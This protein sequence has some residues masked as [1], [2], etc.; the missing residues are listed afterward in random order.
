M[1][2]SE[3]KSIVEFKQEIPDDN[4]SVEYEIVPYIKKEQN[5][6]IYAL[7]QRISSID[8]EIEKLNSEIDQL[9]NHADGLDYIVAVS[10]G[11]LCGIIDSIFV[12]E[13]NFEHAKAI[14]NEE[15]NRK[16]MAFAKKKGW[17]PHEG[18]GE[19]LDLA[20]KY[21]EKKYPL[22]GDG[23]FEQLAGSGITKNTH[24]IDDFC[25]HPN[26]VGLICCLLVQF[27]GETIYYNNSGTKYSIPILV[28]D[29]GQLQ[30]TT[31]V[32][33]FFCGIINWFITVAKT[34]ANAKGHWMSDIAGSGTSKHGGAGLPGPVMSLLKELSALPCFKDS[35]FSE[36]LRKVYQ[37]GIGTGKKQIDLGIFNS[38][39]E[40]ASSKFDIRT[41]NAVKHELKRQAVP[42]V[43][44]EAL[45][46][47][48]YT[49]RHFIAEY[50]LK[51]DFY[52][53]DWKNILPFKNRTIIRMLTISTGTFTAFDLADATIRSAVKNA[54]Q[55]GSPLFI[56]DIILRVNFVGI[57]RFAIAISTDVSMEVKKST[58]EYKRIELFI[59]QN[60]LLNAKIFYRQQEMWIQ[61]AN[62]ESSAKKLLKIAEQSIQFE[63]EAY[64]D[65]LQ[66]VNN[67]GIY[68][69]KAEEKNPGL[70]K[71]LLDS[72]W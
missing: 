24:H 12:G 65:M 7:D 16:V 9:T 72:M 15:I 11:I 18:N 42:V 69:K 70:R 2:F 64:K 49:I 67:I 36:N 33:K 21:L 28:N 45:V 25:H 53:L 5:S 23:A 38:L 40:G 20:I 3:Q 44:N 43:I 48:F 63:K 29:Y 71:K 17:Q 14:S 32:T 58:L 35:N 62:T 4:F 59:E 68:A 61:I 19:R 54:G 22:P 52:K 50:K 55:I 26:I 57:G 10:S 37:N 39:F 31:L 47:G 66:S 34:I 13:W 51:N 60:E 46:R 30:G 27:K 41:E 6:D 8:T 56:K 1:D